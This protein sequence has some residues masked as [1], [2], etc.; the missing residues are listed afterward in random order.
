MAYY[1]ETALYLPYR[2]SEAKGT[3]KV[4]EVC[5][6]DSFSN[7]QPLHEITHYQTV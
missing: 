1:R 4:F 5:R 3:G 2:T 6:T 7:L